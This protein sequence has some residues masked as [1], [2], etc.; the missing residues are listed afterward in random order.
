MAG[1][2]LL[3]LAPML[4]T[5]IFLASTIASPIDV[6]TESVP[7][8]VLQNALLSFNQPADKTEI[9][10][11]AQKLVNDYFKKFLTN[12]NSD[13]KLFVLIFI[14]KIITSYLNYHIYSHVI[15]R[16]LF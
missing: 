7:Q 8:I 5:I 2:F 11:N 12:S 16:P 6:S 4:L 15:Y 1:K 14:F 10:I 9:I 3:K 13:N